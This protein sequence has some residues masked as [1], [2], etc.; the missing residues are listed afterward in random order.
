MIYF[1]FS[2]SAPP[3]AQ[4]APIAEEKDEEEESDEPPKV[5]V[6]TVVEED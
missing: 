1:R 2:F 6:K 5:E 4:T 3:A